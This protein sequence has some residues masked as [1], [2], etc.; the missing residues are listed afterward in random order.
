MTPD[1]A[2]A[3][4]TLMFIAFVVGIVIGFLAGKL[5]E[6]EPKRPTDER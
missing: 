5:H 3:I 2:N 4:F 6:R 1:Q